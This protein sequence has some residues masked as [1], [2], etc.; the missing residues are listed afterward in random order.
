[1][2]IIKFSFS[3]FNYTEKSET[4]RKRNKKP[5]FLPE[6]NCCCNSYCCYLGQKLSGKEVIGAEN[7]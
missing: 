1:M 6:G 7:L 2:L 3:F 4:P 5:L